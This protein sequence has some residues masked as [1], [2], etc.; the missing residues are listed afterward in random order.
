MFS[1]SFTGGASGRVKTSDMAGSIDWLPPQADQHGS[2]LPFRNQSNREPDEKTI[3]LRAL[4]KAIM[5]MLT[6][7]ISTIEGRREARGLTFELNNQLLG[8]FS[9]LFMAENRLCFSQDGK[10]NEIPW[11]TGQETAT[12]KINADVLKIRRTGL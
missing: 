11:T 12:P 7:Y 9:A 10:I 6:D 1:V 3:R 4:W 8:R 5:S 2:G